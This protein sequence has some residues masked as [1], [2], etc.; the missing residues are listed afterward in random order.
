MRVEQL[1]TPALV[2]DLDR[3]E[4]NM[5][6]MQEKLEKTGIALRPHYK[7]HRCTTLALRQLEAGAKGITCAKLG[8]AEDLVAAGV[9]D[10][11]IANQIVDQ[12]KLERLARLALCCRLTV[13][14]DDEENISALSR[15]AVRIGATI[16]CLVEFEVGMQRCGVAS[17]EAFLA[18]ARQVIE[19]DG[20]VLDGIQAYAG[21]LSHE[22]DGDRRRREADKVEETLRELINWLREQGV[23]IR[24]VGGASTGTVAYKRSDSVYTEL[25]AG[26]YLLMDAAYAKL[27]PGFHNALFLYT[28]VVSTAGGRVVTDAGMKSCAVDQGSPVYEGFEN[29]EVHMSEEHSAFAAKPGLL[30]HVGQRLRCIP[31]HGCTTINLHDVLYLARGGE[32]VDCVPVTSRGHSL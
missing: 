25:Q 16:H 21:H 9:K 32:V 23:A 8:E 27:K 22:M 2:V 20:L 6:T 18:L 11:L 5:R 12:S 10:V 31:G 3:M 24:E 15:A 4:E 26:S 14:V 29:V 7:S 28:T 13:C 19:S 30:C 17:R 1:E